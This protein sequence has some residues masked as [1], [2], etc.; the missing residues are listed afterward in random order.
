[1]SVEENKQ[2]IRRQVEQVWNQ[3]NLGK[4]AEFVSAYLLAESLEHTR[5]FLTAFPDVQVTIEDLIGEGDKV[6][7]RLFIRATNTGSFAGRP[8]TGK[9][10]EFRSIRIYQI[11]DGE[12]VASWAMQDRLGLMEQLGQVSPAG[13]VNWADGEAD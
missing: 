10:V 11:L 5:Q 1:M 12:I 6:V 3:H 13:E 7:A 8:P 2:L 9:K 4:A